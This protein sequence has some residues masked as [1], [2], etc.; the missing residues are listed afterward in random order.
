MATETEKSGNSLG[1]VGRLVPIKQIH[2]F[3]S[4]VG[5]IKRMMP[6]VRAV[7]IGDG[8]LREELQ[9]YS[10]E[11]GLGDNIEFLGKVKDVESIL[12]RSKIFVLTSKSEGLSIA[13]AE[14]MAVGVVPVV[15]D[16]GELSDLVIDGV[17]GYLVKPNSIAGYSERIVSLLEDHPMWD[18][19]SHKAIKR[20]K[21]HCGIQVIAEKW[22][23]NLRVVV[24]QASG[25][26]KQE[27]SN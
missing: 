25:H 11:L 15:A 2:Q 16:V 6:N 26:C 21:E 4:S 3:I 1:F 7:I 14:A 10:E 23:Q 5:A 22:K 13:L 27:F 20:A 12:T 24:S 8:P 19:F 17:N 18:Q 9:S